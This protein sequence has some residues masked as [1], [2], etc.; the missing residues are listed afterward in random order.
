MQ[1]TGEEA[2]PDFDGIE[3]PGS[4]RTGGP[5]RARLRDVV[6]GRRTPSTVSTIAE[7]SRT[8]DAWECRRDRPP[9]DHHTHEHVHP[10]LASPTPGA[11]AEYP[12]D[13]RAVLA[14]VLTRLDYRISAF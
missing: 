7:Q 2:P 3:S 10:P 4:L 8:A 9:N 1:S 14:T 13:W 11:D 5:S 12:D 6:V